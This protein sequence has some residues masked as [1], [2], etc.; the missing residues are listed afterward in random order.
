MHAIPSIEAI[1][2]EVE[3]DDLMVIRQGDNAITLPVELVQRLV[4]EI[5][6]AAKEG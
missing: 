3:V 4:A 2:V 6:V 1:H 5:L